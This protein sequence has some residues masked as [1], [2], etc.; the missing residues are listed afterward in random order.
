MN[1]GEGLWPFYTVVLLAP[2]IL[3][4]A[5]CGI[6]IVLSPF[7]FVASMIVSPQ[8]KCAA[9]IAAILLAPWFLWPSI[10]YIA[11]KGEN[12]FFAEDVRGIASALSTVW[13]WITA[14][15][16][17]FTFGLVLLLGIV[18]VGVYL[19]SSNARAGSAAW[20]VI[21]IVVSLLLTAGAFKVHRS[22]G[23]GLHEHLQFP[24]D[25]SGGGLGEAVFW[26]FAAGS[27]GLAAVNVLATGLCAGVFFIGLILL[28]LAVAS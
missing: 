12:S 9:G 11:T 10:Y 17:V 18:D 20:Y 23:R 2:I 8:G 24:I 25:S 28:P 5:L 6:G 22:L 26:R 27:V 1:L 14:A 4:A 19:S 21:D 16:L 3:F 7:L 13:L 15:I